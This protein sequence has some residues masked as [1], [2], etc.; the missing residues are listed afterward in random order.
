MPSPATASRDAGQYP[1]A[2]G[3]LENALYAVPTVELGRP[4]PT[5]QAVREGIHGAR[6][7]LAE[8]WAAR[9]AEE[10]A[11]AAVAEPE[12]EPAPTGRSRREAAGDRGLAAL[13][14]AGAQATRLTTGLRQARLPEGRQVV[15]GAGDWLQRAARRLNAAIEGRPTTTRRRVPAAPP[16]APSAGRPALPGDAGI[17]ALPPEGEDEPASRHA[18]A[19]PDCLIGAERLNALFRRAPSAP[20]GPCAGRSAARRW[21]ASWLAVALAL[22]R[23]GQANGGQRAWCSDSRIEGPFAQGDDAGA[24][25]SGNSGRA[26]GVCIG[27]GAR[28]ACRADDCLWL[29]AEVLRGG[30]HAGGPCASPRPGPRG[31][32]LWNRRHGA[33]DGDS[34]CPPEA[35]CRAAQALARRAEIEGSRVGTPEAHRAPGARGAQYLAAG[36]SWEMRGG[37]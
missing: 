22:A 7:T 26:C 4:A 16:V 10:E 28:G 34:V 5:V 12:P 30:P 24:A 14:R 3:A 20:T 35:A 6:E 8:E 9:R 1:Q 21:S 17:T 37:V 31:R 23:T 2:L 33:E 27:R 25:P 32:G 11:A 13:R 15:R 29:R 18:A 36:R 19:R